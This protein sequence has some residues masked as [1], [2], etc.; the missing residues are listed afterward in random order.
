M[1]LNEI[2]SKLHNQALFN[3]KKKHPE[4]KNIFIDQFVSPELY[5]GYTAFENNVVDNITFKTK[6]ESLYPSVALASMIARYCFLKELEVMNE[7]YNVI[8][9]KGASIKVDEFAKEFVDKYGISE[10]QKV[11]KCNFS[12]YKKLLEDK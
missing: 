12:N 6:A 1:N 3:V 8:F 2:K 9:P 5:Y 4:V 10:L 7:K 11:A